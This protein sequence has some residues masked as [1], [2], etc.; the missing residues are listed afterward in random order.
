[1]QSMDLISLIPL[2]IDQVVQEANGQTA[3][4]GKGNSVIKFF[5]PTVICPHMSMTQSP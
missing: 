1:M 2:D 4:V 3:N 5:C